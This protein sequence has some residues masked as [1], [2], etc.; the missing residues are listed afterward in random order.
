[1]TKTIAILGGALKKNE[2]GEWVIDDNAG[3]HLR[4]LAGACLW[5]KHRDW[6]IIAS[7]GNG[8]I[9]AEGG[10]AIALLMKEALVAEGVKENVISEESDSRNTFEQ[11][12]ALSR[13]LEKKEIDGIV[14]ISNE[15]HLPRIEA[16]IK[17]IA[18]LQS[19]RVVGIELRSAE[20][21]LLNSDPIRWR[22]VIEKIRQSDA[23]REMSLKEQRGVE[24]IRNGT[25][26]FRK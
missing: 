12:M 13:M 1:M 3:N 6:N 20:E 11:L 26:K 4:V 18:E 5:E 24:Q 16:M 14:L 22:P 17:Y 23:Y 8:Q 2:A 10:P 21:V 7:G 25:Y 15:W 9:G 19:L